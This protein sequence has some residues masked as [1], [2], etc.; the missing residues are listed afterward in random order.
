LWA[1]GGFTGHA[2]LSEDI[3][4]SEIILVKHR[5]KERELLHL[6]QASFGHD[7]SAKLWDWKYLQNPLAPDDP[8]VIVAVHNDKIVSA[9]PFLLAE[10]WLGYEKIKVA[11]PC[12]TMVHPDHRREGIFSQMN[13]FA[14]EYFKE[15]GYGFFY[16]FPGTMS[17]PGYLKQG[18]KI[19]A[20]TEILFRAVNP[21]KLASYKLKSQFL[22]NVAG[23]LYDKFLST[24]SGL[25]SL[26]GHF[27]IQVFDQFTEELKLVDTLRDTTKIDL[28]RGERYLRWRFDQHPE[29]SYKYIIA[30]KGDELWGYAVISVQRQLSGLIYGMIVDYVV[31]DNDTE[32]FRVLV[33]RCMAELEESECD[34][35]CVWAFSMPKFREELIKHFDFKSSLSFP[36]NKALEK[37]Y[38]VVRELDEQVLEKI[39]IYKGEN[40]RITHIYIDTT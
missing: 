28:V 3:A 14:I 15:S 33:K 19:V 21:R 30:K 1:M 34:L 31:R 18:W 20:P 16:N 25:S 10:L 13:Q 36:Y 27:Q 2:Q 17:R 7:M 37:G 26:P 11:Q 5:E 32:C 35:V 39:D 8:E 12:D 24:G 29:H 40:W 23:F 6:F 22:G 38:F 4:M 9:R